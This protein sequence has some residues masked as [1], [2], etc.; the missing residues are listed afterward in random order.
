MIS[1]KLNYYFSYTVIF[2][3]RLFLQLSS[4]SFLPPAS[5]CSLLHISRFWIWRSKMQIW[6]FYSFIDNLCFSISTRFRKT[7]EWNIPWPSFAL[8]SNLT[9]STNPNTTLSP[10]LVVYRKAY[11]HSCL[12]YNLLSLPNP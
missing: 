6:S 5:S 9:S 3:P 10:V 2:S 12:S 4:W 1:C 7:T 8:L 11:A